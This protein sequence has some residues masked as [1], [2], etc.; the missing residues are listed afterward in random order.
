VI[1]VHLVQ[2]PTCVDGGIAIEQHP[3]ALVD[4]LV[5]A[6]E[7]GHPEQRGQ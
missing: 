2:S 3:P 4:E 1:A 6:V 5:V 7:R